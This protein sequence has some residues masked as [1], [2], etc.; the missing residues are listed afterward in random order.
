VGDL[1]D[2]WQYSPIT[3]Q[4]TW[5]SGGTGDNVSG[6]YGAEDAT[7]A[8]NLPGSRQGGSSW[9]DSA[10]NLWLFGGYGY[11]STGGKG[12]LNDLW[13]YSPSTGE[14]TWVNGGEGDNAYGAYG[15][16]GT[17]AAANVPGGRQGASSWIDSSGD[18][19]LFGGVG[20][21]P[22]GSGYLSDLWHF[23]VP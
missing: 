11:D 13:E 21:G 8:G 5:I 10:G 22:T 2:L 18:L 3:G 20:Y 15:T 4:W 16:L 1:N 23:V 9:I 12:D 19:W 17:A 7:S 6:I 14:W